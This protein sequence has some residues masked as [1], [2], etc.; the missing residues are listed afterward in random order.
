VLPD[1]RID[2]ARTGAWDSPIYEEF[3]VAV[4]S[5]NGRLPPGSRLRVLAADY[6]IDWVSPA[7]DKP[8]FDDDGK[9]VFIPLFEAGVKLRDL[10][11]ACLYFGTADLE[12]AKPPARLYEGTQDGIEVHRGRR[13]L[14][15]G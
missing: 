12:L 7:A 14:F 9:P 2:S 15:G 4:H 3:I 11:D 13:M 5:V 1:A 6:P 10:V 8:V